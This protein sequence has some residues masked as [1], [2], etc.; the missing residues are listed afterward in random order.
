VGEYVDMTTTAIICI[1]IGYL[2]TLMAVCCCVSE[3]KARAENQEGKRRNE[4]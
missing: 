4:E 3:L 1:T 2:G